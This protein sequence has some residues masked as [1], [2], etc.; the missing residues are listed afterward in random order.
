M[1]KVEILR[2]VVHKKLCKEAADEDYPQNDG[3]CDRG[4]APFGFCGFSRLRFRRL[5][6]NQPEGILTQ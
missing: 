4:A 6:S 5:V 2:V 1:C 3:G